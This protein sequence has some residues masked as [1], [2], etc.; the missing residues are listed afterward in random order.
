[1]A[2]VES[3]TQ[4]SWLF[5]LAWGQV[6]G[7][8][9]PRCCWQDALVFSHLLSTP[10]PV[11]NPLC[12]LLALSESWVTLCSHSRWLDL[13]LRCHYLVPWD[14][15]AFFVHAT[16]E[17][18][19]WGPIT[20]I[21][22]DRH[23]ALLSYHTGMGSREGTWGLMASGLHLG[24]KKMWDSLFLSFLSLP[25]PSSSPPHPHTLSLRHQLSLWLGLGQDFFL[26]PTSFSVLFTSLSTPF[27]PEVSI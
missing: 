14:N 20:P 3:Q 24:G 21:L 16:Q 18:E 6:S 1:M 15:L 22:A 26:K 19:L 10:L 9:G 23:T 8:W 5:S 12:L 13:L 7:A 27:L 11:R 25:T 2:E 17:R 4:P